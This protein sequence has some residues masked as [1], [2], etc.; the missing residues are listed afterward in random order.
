MLSNIDFMLLNIIGEVGGISGY[1]LNE[2]V[3]SRGYREWAGIGKSSIYVRLKNLK[4]K[5]YLVSQL[6]GDKSGK[7]PLPVEYSITAAGKE[8]LKKEILKALSCSDERERRF[9][10]GISAINIV[11][12]KNVLIEVL[13]ERLTLLYKKHKHNLEQMEKVGER[14]AEGLPLHIALLFEH[15]L[16]LIST[17]IKFVEKVIDRLEKGCRYIAATELNQL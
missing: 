4:K 5:G 7:G 15:T 3:E 17:E 2:L 14:T 8:I 13:Q 10:L 6:S 12:E 1:S 9:D 16:A 11:A